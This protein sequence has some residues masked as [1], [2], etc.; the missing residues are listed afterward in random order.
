MDAPM[1]R[2]HENKLPPDTEAC[3]SRPGYLTP[4]LLRACHERI[5]GNF[6]L[7]PREKS[8]AGRSRRRLIGQ[9]ADK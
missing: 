4:D 5:A 2:C 7:V 1:R 6:S 8:E 9:L 3:R